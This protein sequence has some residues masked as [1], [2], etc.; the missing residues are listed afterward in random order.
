MLQET[1]KP[2]DPGWKQRVV[3]SVIP[4]VDIFIG[5]MGHRLP[6]APARNSVDHC[7]WLRRNGRFTY[8]TLRN[9]N[10]DINPQD[11]RKYECNIF[12]NLL[13]L[14]SLFQRHF[15][16]NSTWTFNMEINSITQGL[17]KAF[18]IF[19]AENTNRS[20][21]SKICTFLFSHMNLKSQPRTRRVPGGLPVVQAHVAKWSYPLQRDTWVSICI[22]P[23]IINLQQDIEASGQIQVPAPLPRYP[24]TTRLSGCQ[25]WY[26]RGSHENKICPCWNLNTGSPAHSQSLE[27]TA[28]IVNC[29]YPRR[30]TT[31]SL[32]MHTDLYNFHKY[33][34][35]LK[36]I[37]D[38]F[39]PK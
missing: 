22:A 1:K 9:H 32:N 37:I 10:T 8:P 11:T 29:D 6:D 31:S 15:T 19:N 17:R 35:S 14:G 21:R 28:N 39:C 16:W 12:R 13:Q 36:V 24:F 38:H 23:R 20:V 3:T 25:K 2:K 27:L 26:G 4:R 7:H 18:I 30:M 34:N 5:S 33:P